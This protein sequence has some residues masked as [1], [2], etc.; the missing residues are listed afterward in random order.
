MQQEILDHA[1][2]LKEQ[3]EITNLWANKI[4]AKLIAV[5]PA[6]Y[7]GRLKEIKYIIESDESW[8]VSKTYHTRL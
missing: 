4:L 5:D 2:Q 3:Y 8:L 7:A 6:T 1:F